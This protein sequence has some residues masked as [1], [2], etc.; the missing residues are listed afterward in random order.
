MTL[1]KK[2]ALGVL[3]LLFLIFVGTY[4][5]TMNNAR[6]FFIQ[7]IE[8]NAQDTATSLGLSLSQSL[9]SHDKA[10]MRS[11]VD[12]VFDRGYFSFIQVN[13]MKGNILVSKKLTQQESAI[14]G[15]FLK[16]IQWPS[17][18]KSSLVMD[19]WIQ[20]GIVSVICDPDYAYA[21]LWRNAV[22]MVK[23]YFI[24]ALISLMFVYAF[25]Q[26]LLKP[27]KRVTAQAMAIS[28]HE[29]P[30][31][32]TIPNTPELKQVVLAMNQMVI[33]VRSLFDEQLAQT[34]ALRTQVYQDPLTGLSNHRYFMQQLSSILNNE[35]EFRPGYVIM[36]TIDG[37]N[38]LNQ[39]QGH[40]KGDELILAVS[41]A[42][43]KFWIQN[44]VSTLARINGTTFVVINHER[45]PELFDK[46]CKEFEQILKQTIDG[47]VPCTSY[48]G[49]AGYFAHQTVSNLL[50]LADSSVQ[51]TREKG[52]F[53]C[54]SDHD[55]FK[56]PRLITGDEIKQVLN[57]KS[58]HLYAQGITNG[59][60]FLHRELFVRLL[61]HD[62][63][64]LGAGYF[65]P[66]AEKEGVA[67][68][69]DLYVLKE[70]SALDLAA[71]EC[72][73]ANISEDTLMN[74]EHSNAY[75]QQ[76]KKTPKA[77]L[78]NLAL[79]INES[80]VLSHFTQV[81]QFAK[82]VQKLG[83]KVGVDRAGIHFSPLQYLSDLHLNYL[84]LH[85]SLI[86]GIDENESKQFFIHYFNEMAKTLDVQVVATQVELQVQ[87]DALN[88]VHVSWGQGRYLSPVALLV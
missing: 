48:V 78:H 15:W 43:K 16:L 63:N 23:G 81:K 66:I 4:L 28:R 53:Y 55:A 72:F 10:A 32:T 33:K 80:I 58:M 20:T 64:E 38:D 3:F 46:E 68:L 25:I 52:V 70:L 57:N 75:I 67:H 26:I 36:I 37:L 1:I 82:Q 31:E 5:I 56:Y 86:Q 47:F 42:C 14:P 60:T 8:S 76:L 77:V 40:Q 87:W 34:E 2:M 9:T 13:D 54:Q 22:Q 11:M 27:L 61:H 41:Q 44:T 74:K 79:E 35:D 24:F 85:G 65:M 39:Q 49:A 45:D 18:V 62:G 83:V 7:Q 50:A 6:N 30:I 69:V 29:F 73:A 88:L 71:N 84:K 17:T 59:E 51:M 12:A 21:S 19:G